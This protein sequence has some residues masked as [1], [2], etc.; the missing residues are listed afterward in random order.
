M[1]LVHQDQRVSAISSTWEP[2]FD[3]FHS[4]LSEESL[5]SMIKKTFTIRYF[6][7]HP[8]SN[9]I[10]SNCLSHKRPASGCPHKFRSRST[11]RSSMLDQ[12]FGHLCRG[13]R[14][15]TAGHSDLGILSNLGASLQFYWCVGRY[16][17]KLLVHHNLVIL[18]QHPS[19][20]RHSFGTQTSPVQKT[21]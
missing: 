8:T 5:F 21:A 2:C 11:T 17:I 12:D 3:S 4:C 10:S 19:L 9:R 15:H 7:S 13:R 20:L 6:F 16:C 14:I 1:M 18:Q